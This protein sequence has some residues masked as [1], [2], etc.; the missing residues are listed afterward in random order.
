MDVER[1][2]TTA[3]GVGLLV[4]GGLALAGTVI[5]VTLGGLTLT[6]LGV[7]I[8][9]VG[10]TVAAVGSAV[11]ASRARRSSVAS[12]KRVQ[13]GLQGLA[14]AGFVVVFVALAADLG[15]LAVLVGAALVLGAIFSRG[16][17]E[18]RE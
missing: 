18:R 5:D 7:G 1:T 16:Y 11:V 9:A 8:V 3:Q 2:T 13:A 10:F 14:A 12:D 4:G 6:A 15:V 17:L